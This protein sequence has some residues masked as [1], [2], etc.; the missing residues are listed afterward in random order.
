MH[1]IL[2][3]CQTLAGASDG[4]LLQNGSAV[5]FHPRSSGPAALLAW[6]EWQEQCV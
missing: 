4:V 5:P 1:L 3:G 6:N 2:L